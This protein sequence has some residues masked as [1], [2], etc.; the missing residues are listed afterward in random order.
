M[1]HK[2]L[3]F[4]ERAGVVDLEEPSEGTEDTQIPAPAQPVVSDPTPVV[5]APVNPAKFSEVD[6]ACFSKL[7]QAMLNDGAPLPEEFMDTLSV[8][9][10]IP[11]EEARYKTALSLMS[12]R[13]Y[14]PAAILSDY[15]KTLG[16]LEETS[17]AF[18]GS[19]KAQ[20]DGKVGARHAKVEQL[21]TTIEAHRVQIQAMQEEIQRLTAER[22]NEQSSITEEHLK[23]TTV[24]QRFKVIFTQVKG[25]ILGQRA[26]IT[27][28]GGV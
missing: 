6:K 7:E 10:T 1:A 3:R 28:Y 27:Q 22:D 5:S 2:L 9:D 4:L 21:T 23:I 20:I 11:T 14:T 12:K 8:L 13:G 17:V 16:V 26:K 18:E 25:E 15:D 19:L 24:Q